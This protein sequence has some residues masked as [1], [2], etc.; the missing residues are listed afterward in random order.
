[1]L[2]PLARRVL[3]TGVMIRIRE[4]PQ[5]PAIGASPRHH[6]GS[7]TSPPDGLGS[8]VRAPRVQRGRAP[9]PRLLAAVVG[10]VRET[11]RRRVVCDARGAGHETGVP[12]RRPLE[13]P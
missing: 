6:T 12:G 11:S 5:D 1:M 4:N 9:R 2:I 10:A 13:A 7:R 8:P 3:A